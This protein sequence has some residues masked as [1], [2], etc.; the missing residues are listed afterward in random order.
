M[1]HTSQPTT[2][3]V[4]DPVD[5]WL[6]P[7][8][9]FVY[10]LQHVLAMSQAKDTFVGL[11]VPNGLPQRRSYDLKAEIGKHHIYYLNFPSSPVF[12]QDSLWP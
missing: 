3:P 7:L 5:A 4:S 11:R 9:L 6:P 10:G 2:P 12:F 1:K 8:P